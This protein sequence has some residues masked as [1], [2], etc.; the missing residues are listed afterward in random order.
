MCM[1]GEERRRK[2]GR[3]RRRR[4]E[5]RRNRGEGEE[6]GKERGTGVAYRSEAS[7]CVKEDSLNINKII[8]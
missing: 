8:K 1:W 3:K 6:E 7:C 2:G 4:G 5:E